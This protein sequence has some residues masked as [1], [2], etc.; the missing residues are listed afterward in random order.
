MDFKLLSDI[1][2]FIEILADFAIEHSFLFGLLL[3]SAWITSNKTLPFIDKFL[4]KGKM[5]WDK[6]LYK[7]EVFADD[8]F[9]GIIFGQNFVVDDEKMVFD[10]LNNEI[11]SCQKVGKKL[12]LN[13][14]KTEIINLS[15]MS[16][17]RD[18]IESAI[19]KKLVRIELTFAENFDE[20]DIE[21][22][23]KSLQ[24]RAKK[25]TM[26]NIKRGLNRRREDK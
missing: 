3:V 25:S 22:M 2:K 8:H 11:E 15:T 13:L 4:F 17:L 18:S 16:A 5:G 24:N 20:E 7:L 21:T 23:A 26:V 12:I 1:I 6:K 9:E 10:S 14:S 19:D